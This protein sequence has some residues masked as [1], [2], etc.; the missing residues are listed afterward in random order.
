[1]PCEQREQRREID[2]VAG[3][4]VIPGFVKEDDLGEGRRQA[5]R[6]RPG[7][8]AQRQGDSRVLNEDPVRAC[9]MIQD[10]LQVEPVCPGVNVPRNVNVPPGPGFL[11][12]GVHAVVMADQI[13]SRE[14]VE[15]GLLLVLEDR[16]VDVAVFARLVAEPGI[17]SP[18]AAEEPCDR[19]SRHDVCHARDRVGDPIHRSSDT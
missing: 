5:P 16:H 18:T 15:D 10:E 12:V 17:D 6:G 14:T 11:R 2:F 4:Y 7:R 1:L 8:S 19:E 9:A 13:P 3:A